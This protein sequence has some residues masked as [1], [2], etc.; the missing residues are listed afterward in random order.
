MNPE[1]TKKKFTPTK[2]MLAKFW[3]HHGPPGKIP[4]TR[5]WNKT[6]CR[7]AKKRRVVSAWRRGR[8]RL[9][10]RRHGK[11]RRLMGRGCALSPG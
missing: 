10:V 7:A 9:V 4:M 11:A 2:P 5:I 1:R 8:I 3:Y 6:T